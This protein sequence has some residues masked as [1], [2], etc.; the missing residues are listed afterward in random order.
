MLMARV[1]GAQVPAGAAV[2]GPAVVVTNGEGIVSVAPDRAFVVLTTESRARQPRDAQNQNSSMMNAV[3]DKLRAAGVPK[4]SVRTVSFN[5]QQEFDY[6]GGRPVPRDFVARHAI[7]VRLDDIQR[8]GELLDAAVASGATA[9][10][11][12]RFDLKDRPKAER[13]ALRLAVADARARA[14]AAAAGTG[15]TI[16]RVIKIEERGAERPGPI[17]V[18]M[19]TRAEQAPTPVA[20]GELEIRASVTL[21]ASIK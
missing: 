18:A 16:D 5:L 9:V 4:D 10:S 19:M 17:P 3:Q 2:T 14:D 12:I 13:E 21:T 6:T 15:A 7:E 8:V 20:Q 11:Q 1:A